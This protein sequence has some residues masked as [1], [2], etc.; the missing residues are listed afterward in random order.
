MMSS[1]ID[2]SER[3]MKLL[4]IIDYNRI[5]RL[6]DPAYWTNIVTGA[7][8]FLVLSRLKLTKLYFNVENRVGDYFWEIKDLGTSRQDP[9]L[10]GAVSVIGLSPFC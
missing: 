6:C 10:K 1:K 2:A 5:I 9:D 3:I 7:D 8:F 4:E